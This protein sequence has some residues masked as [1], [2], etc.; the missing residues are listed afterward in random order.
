VDEELGRFLGAI[1]E[2][3][4]TIL[5]VVPRGRSCCSIVL[6]GAASITDG[7]TRADLAP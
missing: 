2:T 4:F 7:P 5:A 1:R 6:I 3:E